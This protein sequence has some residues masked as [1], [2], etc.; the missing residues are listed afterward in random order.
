MKKL[1]F[2]ALLLPNGLWA[3][4]NQVQA[5]EFQ[6]STSS[7]TLPLS[8]T[9]G[10]LLMAT[11]ATRTGGDTLTSVTSGG[12]AWTRGGYTAPSGGV[13]HTHDSA[14]NPIEWWE[15][16]PWRHYFYFLNNIA[17]GAVTVTFSGSGFMGC[18]ALWVSEWSGFKAYNGQVFSFGALEQSYYSC[19]FYPGGVVPVNYVHNG[20]V[21]SI[22]Y[23]QYGSL[24][25]ALANDPPVP[26]PSPTPPWYN[27][28][29]R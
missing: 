17:G 10:N 28:S 25:A 21:G 9:A 6:E 23:C 15:M 3:Q 1:I 14:G 12:T 22:L 24:A 20:E 18:D 27:S 7:V 19:A 2:A 11:C 8:T 13:V 5:V 26:D 29:G 4:Y 16:Q